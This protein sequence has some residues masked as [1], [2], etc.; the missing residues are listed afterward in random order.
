MATV[1]ATWTQ[2]RF[3]GGESW[4][5]KVGTHEIV[6]SKRSHASI[7]TWGSESDKRVYT[8]EE[9]R[10]VVLSA[11][12]EVIGNGFAYDM[13]NAVERAEQDIAYHAKR[14]AITAACDSKRD[15][16]SRIEN[17]DE[18]RIALIEAYETAEALLS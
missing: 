10:Y 15:A 18:R 5:G 7:T 14:V 12:G 4:R 9:G 13:P 2:V 11:D 1:K 3:E 8:N 17:D 16:I 6:W